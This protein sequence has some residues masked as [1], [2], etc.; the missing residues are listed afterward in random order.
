MGKFIRCL[1]A[2]GWCNQVQN[3][4]TN[5]EFNYDV[6]YLSLIRV[7][8]SRRLLRW[9]LEMYMEDKNTP[10]TLYLFILSP[11]IPYLYLFLVEANTVACFPP[12]S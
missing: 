8:I 7:T 1:K 2:H 9:K 11:I 10:Y 5:Y 12:P 6:H 4:H 3:N